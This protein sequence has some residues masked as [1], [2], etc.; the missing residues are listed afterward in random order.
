[1]LSADHLSPILSPLF[2][3]SSP[4]TSQPG[5]LMGS[6]QSASPHLPAAHSQDS[7]MSRSSRPSGRSDLLSIVAIDYNETRVFDFFLLLLPSPGARNDLCISSF[8]AAN[9]VYRISLP[10]RAGN[11]SS[12]SFAFATSFMSVY[13]FLIPIF[14]VCFQFHSMQRETSDCSEHTAA[15][16]TS[17]VFW[18]G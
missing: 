7:F 18:A 8:P 11:L 5:R 17:S 14:H 13:V 10:Q 3:L 2:S 6:I 16:E 15:R 9:I 4:E 1:M 12:S